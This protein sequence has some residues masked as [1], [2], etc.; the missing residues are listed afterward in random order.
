[1]AGFQTEWSGYPA[2]VADRA[3]A[4]PPTHALV[5]LPQAVPLLYIPQ[6]CPP[7]KK[8]R[9]VD[10]QRSVLNL[11]VAHD[12]LALTDPELLHWYLSLPL[13]DRKIIQGQGGLHQFLL[14]H[15]ALNLSQNLI[16][17]K[18][19]CEKPSSAV[20]S[21]QYR[22]VGRRGS[23]QCVD[24]ASCVFALRCTMCPQHSWRLF[25][26]SAEGCRNVTT[27]QDPA[28]HILHTLDRLDSDYNH[29]KQQILAAVPLEFYMPS[30]RCV[31]V[32]GISD[33]LPQ[34]SCWSPPDPHMF[35]GAA[36]AKCEEDCCSQLIERTVETSRPRRRADA[37]QS[38]SRGFR[39]DEGQTVVCEDGG[40]LWYDAEDE[41]QLPGAPS[42]LAGSA[43]T[44]P[45]QQGGGHPATAPPSSS[46]RSGA[47]VLMSLDGK[48]IFVPQTWGTMGSVCM[49]TAQLQRLHPNASRGAITA[50]VTVLHA[51]QKGALLSLPLESILAMTSDLLSRQSTD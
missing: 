26:S 30:A 25:Y 29:M 35:L 47:D 4:V 1:M 33:R 12:H 15:P 36:E 31:P 22:T 43:G 51:E 7:P 38:C 37:P 20:T 44:P 10:L 28:A 3:P 8:D 49:L 21:S 16:F 2:T 11:V 24:G 5:F 23:C 46:T 18:Y 48:R 42:E 9:M 34:A 39:L 40:E 45:L 41:L 50:A 14:R 13:E 6:Q 32:Q 27:P 17:L 19:K